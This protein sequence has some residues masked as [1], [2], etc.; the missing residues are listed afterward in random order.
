MNLIKIGNGGCKSESYFRCLQRFAFLGRASTILILLFFLLLPVSTFSQEKEASLIIKL[1]NPLSLLRNDEIISID[2]PQLKKKNLLFNKNNFYV[3]EGTKELPSQLGRNNNILFLASFLPKESKD[4]VVHFQQGAKKRDYK[5]RTQAVL[6]VKTGYKKINGYYTGGKFV[7]VDSTTVPT[8]HFAH[9]AH[10][11]IEGPGWESDKVVYRFYLD[12]RNRN[13]IFGKKTNDLIL[14]KIGIN[15]LIS[16]SKESYTKMLSWG[17]DIFKVGESL[18]IGSIAMWDGN[19]FQTVSKTDQI[20]CYIH[21]GP[22]KSGVFTKYYGWEVDGKRYNLFS[23]LSI[24]A[25]S[26]LT[27]VDLNLTDNPEYLCTGLAKH[28]NC[29]LI[30]SK[31]KDLKWG[32]LALYGKQSL[33]G[34][35]LGTVV[36]YKNSDLVKTTENSTSE[37]VVLKVNNEKLNYYFG[38]AWQKEMNGIKNL[39]QFKKYLD[40]TATRLSNPI[41]IKY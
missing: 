30:K 7:D 16:N 5:K 32:Y 4:V 31:N 23:H 9:D 12:S 28:E 19:T 39:E 11:R 40:Y 14:Q 20:K 13:D 24:A 34:D 8:D 3:T 26:R 17:M 29:M 37:I 15:D 33:S 21:N 10:F 6:G 22:I 35:N 18:G 2:V 38:S 36:F 41:T 27:R 1:Q 25:G